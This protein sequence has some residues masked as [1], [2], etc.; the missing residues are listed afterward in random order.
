MGTVIEH[1]QHELGREWQRRR[2]GPRRDSAVVGSER[3]ATP[4]VI[5]ELA[6]DPGHVDGVRTGTFARGQSPAMPAVVCELER[7]I[8][9]VLTLHIGRAPAVL[10]I[11]EALGTH[12]SVLDTAKVH[13]DMGELVREQRP[14]LE[15]VISV[16][17]FPS[18]SRNPPDVAFLWQRISGRAESHDIQHKR[19]VI[20]FPPPFQKS[21]FGLPPVRDRSATVLRPR[22][23]SAAIK[24]VGKGPYFP[25]VSRIRVKIRARS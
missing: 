2:H 8:D 25:F 11:V 1:G 23:V 18:V 19:L 22:P 16:T 14:R 24:R 17:V 6:L 15:I 21:A 4:H 9:G 7:V 5:E 13:P 20:T 12:E 3:Y 10:E